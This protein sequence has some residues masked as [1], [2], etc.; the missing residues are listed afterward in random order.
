[1]HQL[2][3]PEENAMNVDPQIRTE[4][5][6]LLAFVAEQIQALRN[7]ASGLSESQARETPTRSALSIG[8]LL[9]HAVYV[10]DSAQHR[11]DHPDGRLSPEDYERLLP[12]F[13]A[14]FALTE[15]ESLDG[16]LAEFDRKATGY[17]A[18]LAGLDPDAEINEPAAPWFGRPDPT[19]VR[20]RFY[21]LHQ[22]EELARHAG[23]AD[24]VREQLDGATSYELV[25]DAA[26]AG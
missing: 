11:L 21:L 26:Q 8:G 19:P 23:H 10:F 24:I 14:S 17:L 18:T 9:K 5:D 15:D 16:M 22:I 1:M 12:A 7:A 20:T 4:R 2:P 25:P 3:A 6:E 13:E